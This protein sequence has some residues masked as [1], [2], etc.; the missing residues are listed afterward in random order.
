MKGTTNTKNYNRKTWNGRH[1]RTRQRREDN[2]KRI[3]KKNIVW[4]WTGCNRFR[5]GTGG[6]LLW[7]R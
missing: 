4:M 7:T 1:G 6:G 3:L 5:T 2:I